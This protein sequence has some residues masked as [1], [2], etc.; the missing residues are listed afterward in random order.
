MGLDSYLNKMPR[1]KNA[2][3][4]D[5]AAVENYLDWMKAKEEG[6]EYANGTF[7]DWCRMD[8]PSQE[9]IGCYSKFYENK[10]SDWDTEK[11]YGYMRIMDQVGYWRKQNAIHNWF[12][13]NVQGGA[14]DCNYHE[15]VTKEDL[16]ELL[17]L[18]NSVLADIELADELLPTQGGF[19]F[20]STEYDDWY[21]DGLQYTV[22]KIYDIFNKV[23]FE[24]EM[25]YYISSW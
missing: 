13:K 20:G 2:T 17:R 10:Y 24:K 6:S 16:R 18:C 3:A 9:I 12:V 4:R 1:Y 11:K 25:V 7:Y 5:V 23:D 8:V 22:D 21:K 19:F 15:E 14:D